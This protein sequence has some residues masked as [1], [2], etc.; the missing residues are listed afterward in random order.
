MSFS[1]ASCCMFC[2]PV[3]YAS[4][5]SAYWPIAIAPSS[6]NAAAPICRPRLCHPPAQPGRLIVANT[7]IAALCAGLRCFLP[8]NFPL[9]CPTHLSPKTLHDHPLP[10]RSHPTSPPPHSPWGQS[11]TVATPSIPH[12]ILSPML[13]RLPY[14]KHPSSPL[15]AS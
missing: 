14:S 15:R 4:V 13:L 6:C 2:P 12:R 5:T 8:S 9:G 3:S 1:V 10:A 7:A 11:R